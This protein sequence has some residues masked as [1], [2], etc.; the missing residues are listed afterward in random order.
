MIGDP[1][2][3]DQVVHLLASLPNSYDM[4]VTANSEAV[5][6]FENVTERIL[7]KERKIKDRDGNGDTG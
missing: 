2:D 5:P 4:L 7:H 3:E 1:I 6:K